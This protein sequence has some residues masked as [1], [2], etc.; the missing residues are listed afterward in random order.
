MAIKRIGFTDNFAPRAWGPGGGGWRSQQGLAKPRAWGPGGSGW[1]SEQ[2][3]PAPSYKAPPIASAP[4]PAPVATAK[5]GGST[6][7]TD[8]PSL[9]DPS[10]TSDP[11]LLKVRKLHQGR[12]DDYRAGA[13]SQKRQLAIETGDAGFANELGLDAAT[14]QAARDNP[15]SAFAAIRDAGVA[16]GRD[17]TEGLNKANLLFSGYRGTQLG[18]LAKSLLAREAN[19]QAQA[20]ARY[21]SIENDLLAGLG[22]ADDLEMQAEADA[23]GREVDRRRGGGGGGGAGGGDGSGGGE[24]GRAHV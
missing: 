7:T 8:R 5:P 12:R 21:G 4:A 24:I 15:L 16:E 19:A 14:V 17:L 18:E 9:D 22:N 6:A 11:L 20:R 23:Y 10:I 1:Q 3:L 2:G 13:L